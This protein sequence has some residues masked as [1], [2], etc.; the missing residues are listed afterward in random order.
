MVDE[1]GNARITDFGLAAIVR[2]PH[3]MRSGL[4]EDSYTTRWCAPEILM[5]E[6]PAGK[7]SD[8]F[9][10]GMVI[11]EVGDDQ[12]V[13][14]KPPYPLMKVF[15]GNAPFVGRTTPAVI[16]SIVGGRRPERPNHPGLMDNLW[17]LTKKCLA[18]APL[19]RP[20]VGQVLEALRKF[21]VPPHLDD[22]H[23]IRGSSLR[24][25]DQTALTL[26]KLLG[27]S[28]EQ[29]AMIANSLATSS[30]AS[31]IPVKNPHNPQY[32][33]K[34]SSSSG[35]AEKVSFQWHDINDRGTLP[36]VPQLTLSSSS[37]PS[38]F[39]NYLRSGSSSTPE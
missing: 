8:V 26:P 32:L 10:F 1:F 25:A 13:P 30:S 27:R 38:T 21:S 15:T 7:E 3:S 24:S 4:D 33:N 16:I 20:N 35:E 5:G 12:F 19:N 2:D 17:E 34:Q 29:G 6:Q 31:V 18:Q 23:F 28:P 22:V 37:Y 14:C 39:R 11:I 36:F 9:S